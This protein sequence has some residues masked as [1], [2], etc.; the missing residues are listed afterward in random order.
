MSLPTPIEKKDWKAI[1]IILGFFGVGSFSV[2]VS[3]VQQIIGWMAWPAIENAQTK[4]LD[5]LRAWRAE[6]QRV[7]HAVAVKVDS[8]AARQEIVVATIAEMPG[9]S[10]A[11]RRRRAKER[12]KRDPLF[13]IDDDRSSFRDTKGD[14]IP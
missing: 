3:R 4:A 12:A 10:A 2:L 6:D 13:P 9:A 8:I 1:F 7:L 14:R 5:S 11:A